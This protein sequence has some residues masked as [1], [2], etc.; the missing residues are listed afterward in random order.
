MYDVISCRGA[1]IL[2]HVVMTRTAGDGGR[3]EGEEV[4]LPVEI[5][6]MKR[7]VFDDSSSYSSVCIFLDHHHLLK[8]FEYLNNKPSRIV[9]TYICFRLNLEKGRSQR[10][11]FKLLV[12]G[13]RMMNN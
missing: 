2:L 5:V 1:N 4:V 10:S 7:E 11:D 3:Q 12:V 8:H 6:I 13:N 9:V